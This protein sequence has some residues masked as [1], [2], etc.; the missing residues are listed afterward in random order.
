M[1][2][3]H[4]AVIAYALVVVA[5]CSLVMTLRAFGFWR[6]LEYAWADHKAWLFDAESDDC[7]AVEWY[8]KE[9]ADAKPLDKP[10]PPKANETSAGPPP[11]PK[12]RKRV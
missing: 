3:N 4:F 5:L 12:K 10:A 1:P 8:D 2:F 11:R 9:Y 6:W 7:D